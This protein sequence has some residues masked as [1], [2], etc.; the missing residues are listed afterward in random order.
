MAEVSITRVISV[1]E[2]KKESKYCFTSIRF[3][4]IITFLCHTQFR[5][6]DYFILQGR[7]GHAPPLI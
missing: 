6:L 5:A 2:V 3:L 7:I 1:L 4:H